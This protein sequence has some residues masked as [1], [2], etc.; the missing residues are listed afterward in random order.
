MTPR[1]VLLRLLDPEKK[2]SA[3]QL[4]ALNDLSA[5]ELAEFGKLWL[6]IDVERRRSTISMLVQLA[7][8]NVELN[9]DAVFRF[10]LQDPDAR[11]RLEALDGLGECEDPRLIEPLL[12]L[13]KEDHEE[14]VRAA[15]AGALGKFVLLAELNKL[16]PRYMSNIKSILLEM[17]KDKGQ[18]LEV[19]RRSL[20]A[21]SPLSHP[22]VAQAIEEAY[23]SSELPLQVSALYAMGRNCDPRW[24]PILLKELSSPYPEMRYEAAHACGELGEEAAVAHLIPLLE[25]KDPEVYQAAI[26]ALGKIGGREAKNA[27]LHLIRSGDYAKAVIAQEALEELEA[28]EEFED[29]FE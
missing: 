23:R 22:E 12:H 3:S 13:L 29:E 16:S 27:L 20:E 18:P 26:S 5:Q 10:C 25:D 28:Y 11:V 7:E 6:Q 8:D 4:T 1:E 2:V 14:A 17:I 24:L 15:A 19:R 9:F 21:I